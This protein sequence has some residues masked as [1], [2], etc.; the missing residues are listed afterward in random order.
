MGVLKAKRIELRTLQ[1]ALENI[2]T[3]ICENR[4]CSNCKTYCPSG[5]KQIEIKQTTKIINK[6]MWDELQKE[7]V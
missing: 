1:D 2:N 4:G 5:A 6:L 3:E 7:M